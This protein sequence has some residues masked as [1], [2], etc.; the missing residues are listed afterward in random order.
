MTNKTNKKMWGIFI[1]LKSFE[2]F[3]V[4]LYLVAGYYLGEYLWT[5]DGTTVSS[6]WGIIW[7]TFIGCY[8]L[9]ICS[10]L[11]LAC[12]YM[13]KEMVV[14]GIKAVIDKNWEWTE[15][16]Y[17]KMEGKTDKDKALPKE[18]GTGW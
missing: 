17:N 13:I 9:L 5:L 18:F 7:V 14:A 12:G 8:I 11:L 16:L 4:G 6:V 15:S 2:A 10:F 1:A 3:L